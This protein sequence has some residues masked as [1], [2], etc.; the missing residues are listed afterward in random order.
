MS[1]LGLDI[2][3]ANIK[4]ADARGKTL[5]RPFAI[6]KTPE[7]LS[8]ELEALLE[9][10]SGTS[11]LAVTM[12]AELADC[13]ATK[14][15]GVLRILDQV[16]TAAGTRTCRVWTTRGEF[17]T[18]AKARLHP[19]FIAAANWH[20]LASWVAAHRDMQDVP[21]LLVDIGTT[22][23]DLIPL[24]NR[25][26]VTIG[27]TD[28]ERLIS[29][30][31]SYSGVRRTPLCAVAERVPFRLGYCPLAAELFATTLD[32]Y[33]LLGDLPEAPHDYE[34]ANGK[35]ATIT[36]AHDRIA[37]QLCGDRDEVTL[38]EARDIARF[39]AESQ[40]RRLS[41]ALDRVLA[42]MPRCEQVIV[43]GSGSFLAR[44]LVSTRESLASARV[45][46]LDAWSDAGVAESA[47]AYALA[48]LAE[49]RE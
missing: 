19:R 39:L 37:R 3:G 46:S 38:D 27:L 23:T 47:C 7:R 48:R 6:W 21:S 34:T 40:R 24:L 9:Q 4:A 33:L 35:S 42:R 12:T 31:L 8:S 22:T 14:A 30:E 36:A 5:C 43:S 49:S 2:G 13:F 15:E 10:F 18:P 16:E 20:A 29:G 17:V 25:R 44:Q 1:V 45:H 41:E 26:P 11:T 32:I 28:V